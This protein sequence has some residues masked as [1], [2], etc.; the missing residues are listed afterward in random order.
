MEGFDAIGQ[1]RT[2][3]NGRPVDTSGGLPSA[4]VA[5]GTLDGAADLSRAIADAPQTASCFARQWFRFG[6]GRLE[7]NG[8]AGDAELLATI[9]RAGAE[10]SL[11]EAL[12]ALVESDAFR[13][14]VEPPASAS[15]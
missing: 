7:E 13:Y 2:E 15:E 8:D 5:D 6:L 12:L 4:G 10:S 1:F 11:R 14:R 9:A 3:E